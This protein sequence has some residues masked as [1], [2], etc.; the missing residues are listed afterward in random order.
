MIKCEGKT[1]EQH[2]NES[3]PY[4]VCEVSLKADTQAEVI[5]MGAIASGVEFLEDGTHLSMGSTCLCA[6]C[7]FGVLK[8]DGSWEF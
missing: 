1:I 4:D 6:N 5:S 8:S 7:D 2:K 3:Q